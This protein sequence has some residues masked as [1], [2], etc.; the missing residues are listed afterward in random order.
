[1]S[2]LD[3]AL[4]LLNLMLPALW[5][6][7]AMCGLNQFLKK[8]KPLPVKWIALFAIHFVAC[9]LVLLIGLVITGRDGKMLTYLA[10][11]LTSATIQWLIASRWRK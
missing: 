1:M 4:H 6:A 3:A 10:M 2:L 7:L 8:N 9:L 5:M 11:L